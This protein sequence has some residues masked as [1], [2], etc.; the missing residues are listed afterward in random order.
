M[1]MQSLNIKELQITQ[2]RHPLLI[3][4]GK[5]LSSTPVE[6]EK[7]FIKCAQKGKCTSSMCEQSN[8]KLKYIGKKTV[9]VTDYTNQTPSK[10]FGRKNV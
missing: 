2:T 3:S 7:I 9:G 4:D 6:N 1:I 8:A 5:G 10:H